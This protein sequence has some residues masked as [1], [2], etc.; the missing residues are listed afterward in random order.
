MLLMGP[1]PLSPDKL[2]ARFCRVKPPA[3]WWLVR[4]MPGPGFSGAGDGYP[5]DPHR[6]GAIA[7]FEPLVFST[8]TVLDPLYM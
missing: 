4:G 7:V 6:E 8:Y 2:P 5:K 3:R 1:V